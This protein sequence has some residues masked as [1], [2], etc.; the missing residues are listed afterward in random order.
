MPGRDVG[1]PGPWKK[2]VL[3]SWLADLGMPGIGLGMPTPRK[4]KVDSNMITVPTSNVAR[5]INVFT[6]F[7]SMCFIIILVV[8]HPA[9]LARATKS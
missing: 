8:E 7:G 5:T 9:T 3:R 2:W 1:M 4:L 6:T